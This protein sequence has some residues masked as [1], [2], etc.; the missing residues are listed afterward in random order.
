MC[1]RVE[2][3]QMHGL[4]GDAR[5]AQQAELAM[6]A[7]VSALHHGGDFCATLDGLQPPQA[8]RNAVSLAAPHALDVQRLEPLIIH[9]PMQ[10]DGIFTATSK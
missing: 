10:G 6:L 1:S 4:P 5:P 3:L 8:R 2:P 7:H 9:P